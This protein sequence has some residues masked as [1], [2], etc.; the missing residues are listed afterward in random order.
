[1]YNLKVKLYFIY[2]FRNKKREIVTSSELT[3]QLSL[4]IV[5]ISISQ[6]KVSNYLQGAILQLTGYCGVIVNNNRS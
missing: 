6:Q 2:T 4:R 5:S 1:M 3:L